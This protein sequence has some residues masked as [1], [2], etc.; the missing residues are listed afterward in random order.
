MVNPQAADAQF[1]CAHQKKCFRVEGTDSSCR[2]EQQR[3]TFFGREIECGPKRASVG[4]HSRGM[5]WTL[6]QKI[7]DSSVPGLG[8]TRGMLARKRKKT[9]NDEATQNSVLAH[10]P[11]S[12]ANRFDRFGEGA[13][14]GRQSALSCEHAPCQAE[15]EN[16]RI[17]DFLQ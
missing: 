10:L 1:L 7:I 15:T 8:L 9:A 13:G 3:L 16:R 4:V 17:N 6:L 12:S 5:H 11:T 14:L 2:F